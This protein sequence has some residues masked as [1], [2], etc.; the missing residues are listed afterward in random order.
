MTESSPIPNHRAVESIDMEEKSESTSVHNAVLTVPEDIESS[1]VNI[2][3][4]SNLHHKTIM[5]ALCTTVFV[6]SLDTFIMTN[7]H[8]QLLPLILKFQTSDMRG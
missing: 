3:Q 5:F 7:I 1:R 2:P 8:F 4:K 6:V